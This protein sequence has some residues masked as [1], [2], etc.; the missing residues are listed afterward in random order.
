MKK[1]IIL[2]SVFSLGLIIGSGRMEKRVSASETVLPTNKIIKSN[3]N[4]VKDK[5]GKNVQ[6]IDNDQVEIEYI[7]SN[8]FF[9]ILIT[10]KDNYNVSSEFENKVGEHYSDFYISGVSKEKAMNFYDKNNMKQK[11]IEWTWNK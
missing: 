6:R 10:P 3:A 11:G 9:D 1:I 8:G 2:G 7:E 5:N 4:I